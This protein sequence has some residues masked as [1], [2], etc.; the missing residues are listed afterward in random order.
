MRLQDVTSARR[1][2]VYDPERATGWTSSI[3]AFV[4]GADVYI[5]EYWS[6]GIIE[7]IVSRLHDDYGV[8]L[9]EMCKGMCG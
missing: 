4:V 9:Q 8:Q 3:Q 1:G 2:K 5:F 7:E 6:H